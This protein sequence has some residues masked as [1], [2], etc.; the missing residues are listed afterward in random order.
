MKP[1]R[2]WLFSGHD[3]HVGELYGW[4]SVLDYGVYMQ[5]LGK[6][7]P[8]KKLEVYLGTGQINGYEIY[9]ITPNGKDTRVKHFNGPGY[10]G[11]I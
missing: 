4:S 2:K 5:S 7:S 9:E 10:V 8:W 1:W 3:E 11:Q 6:K